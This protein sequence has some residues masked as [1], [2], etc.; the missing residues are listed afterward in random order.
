MNFECDLYMIQP[1]RE[2]QVRKEQHQVS[3]LQR[4]QAC[5]DTH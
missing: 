1:N 2:R 3:V 5:Q 4:Q